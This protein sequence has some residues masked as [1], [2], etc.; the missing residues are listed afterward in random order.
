MLIPLLTLKKQKQIRK[1]TDCLLCAQL[2]GSHSRKPSL[3]MAPSHQL[4]LGTPARTESRGVS[5][6]QSSSAFLSEA[7]LVASS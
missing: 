3:P 4:L 7:R 1:Y 5:G 2:S 6:V